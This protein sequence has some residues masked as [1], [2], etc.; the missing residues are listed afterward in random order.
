MWFLLNL[1]RFEYIRRCFF[2]VHPFRLLTPLVL[3]VSVFGW[4]AFHCVNGW[5]A[6]WQQMTMVTQLS[7]MNKQAMFYWALRRQFRRWGRRQRRA[8]QQP[9]DTCGCSKWR[10]L[11]PFGELLPR[12]YLCI[13]TSWIF[14]KFHMLSCGARNQNYSYNSWKVRCGG[15]KK[16]QWSA[17]LEG[18]WRPCQCGPEIETI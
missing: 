8:S 15:K 13:I 9:K 16:R 5:L 14:L 18:P 11:N 17:N 2:H 12:S 1:Y 7:C 6:D 10:D 4:M 3:P